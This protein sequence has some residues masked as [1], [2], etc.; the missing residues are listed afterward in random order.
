[1]DENKENLPG[2]PDNGGKLD[3]IIDFA[4]SHLSLLII[5]AGAALILTFIIGSVT[6]AIQ[7]GIY[8]HRITYASSSIAQSK[9]DELDEEAALLLEEAALLARHYDYEAA[10]KLL[11]SFSGDMVE[12]PKLQRKYDEYTAASHDVVLWSDP[13]TILHLSFQNLI[14]DPDRAFSDVRNGATFKSSYITTSEFT[15]IL[16]Q[17]YNNDYVLVRLSDITSSSGAKNLYLPAGKKP[18]VITQTSVNYYTFTLDS[19]GDKLPDAGGSGFASKLVLDANGFVTCEMVDSSG[20]TVYGAYDLVPILDSFIETHPGFSYKG[21]KAIL[22]VTGYD[23]L[24]GY[25]TNPEARE[26]FGDEFFNKELEGASQIAQALRDSGYELACYTYGNEPYG[27]L[28]AEQIADEMN[29]W[30]SEVSPILGFTN[31][32]VFAKNSDIGTNE[33]LYR[34]EK[35]DAL[36]SAGFRYYIGFCENAEPWYS[37]HGNYVRQG[38]IL[39]TGNNLAYSPG[40]YDGLFDPSTVLDGAR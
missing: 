37:S 11:K 13:D 23:G 12:Y 19:D 30:K 20:N 18:L 40:M 21:A 14:A 4:R 26:H 16:Q 5:L 2:K 36:Y 22:A 6:R 24:F 25:R 34:T 31:I 28:S 9:Q 7:K 32:F 10:A 33:K 8:E 35:F 17:L 27:T 39:V 15:S 3:R 1:M 29:R 38:R